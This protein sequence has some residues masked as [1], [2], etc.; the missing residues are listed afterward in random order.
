MFF[1]VY[2][3][4]KHG[5][6][7]NKMKRRRKAMEKEKM[8]NVILLKNLPSNI[9]E[10]A[11]VVLKENHK[12]PA[13]ERKYVVEEP[14]EKG[15]EEEYIIKEAEMLVMEYIQKLENRKQKRN[16]MDWWK[17]YKQLKRWNYALIVLSAVLACMQ[18]VI[19]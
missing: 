15:E 13:T 12:L 16:T 18:I 4:E 5:K 19:K 9:V 1:F 10:E 6:N 17:K 2:K 8:E 11:I 7:P 3:T 14:K